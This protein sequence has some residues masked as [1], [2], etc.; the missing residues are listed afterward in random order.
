MII[1]TIITGEDL[2]ER[3]EWRG[4]WRL[5]LAE[6]TSEEQQPH[7]NMGAAAEDYYYCYN[8]T[9]IVLYV[10]CSTLITIVRI[11]IFKSR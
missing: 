9:V 8:N 4:G 2:R 5:S 10:L 1:I 7:M 11:I 3:I 6:K